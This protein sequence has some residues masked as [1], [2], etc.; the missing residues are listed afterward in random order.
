M[1]GRTFYEWSHPRAD[2]NA[3]GSSEKFTVSRLPAGAKYF[4]VRAFDQSF[5]CSAISNL[6]EVAQGK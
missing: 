1:T 3:P 4:A 6:V 5:N 2:Q